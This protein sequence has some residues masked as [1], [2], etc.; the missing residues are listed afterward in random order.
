MK[1]R[2]NQPE[3]KIPDVDRG[4]RVQYSAAKRS[5]KPWRWYLIIAVSSLPVVYLLAVIIWEVI[6]IEANGRI[7]VPNFTVRTVVDGYVGQLFV[8]PLQT[9]SEGTRLAELVNT[10]LLDNRDRL[11]VE[12]EALKQ[13]KRKM[14]RQADDSRTSSM[15]LIKFA[16][17]QKNFA[18]QR[19]GQYETLFKQGAATQAEVALAR[20]QYNSALENLVA[21]EREERQERD[22]LYNQEHGQLP[23]IRMLSGQINQLQL[24]FDKIQDQIHQLILIAPAGNGMVT[25]LFAQPGEFLGRG[26]PLLEII[27]PEKVHIDAYIPPKYQ[28]YAVVG[29]IVLVKFPNGE[30]AKAKIVSVPGVMQKSVTAEI[31]LLETVQFAILVQMEFVENVKNRL[32]NGMPVTIHLQ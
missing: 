23:E 8:E 32:I 15:Q 1:I 6:N 12:L 29:K 2:F 19:L 11:Q 13:E 27:Y 26:Q 22:K 4:L 7:R 30:K 14:V 20:G 21:L 10:S 3:N 5:A 17:E 16:Q 25:E 18:A 9:V 31:N 28:D 24:E